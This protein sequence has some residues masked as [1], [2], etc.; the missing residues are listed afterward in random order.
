MNQKGLTKAFM[1]VSNLKKA[2]G[3][4]VFFPKLFSA[5]RVNLHRLCAMYGDFISSEARI[6]DFQLQIKETIKIKK[7]I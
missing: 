4:K 5:L 1:M 6:G 7:N 2:S 3:C